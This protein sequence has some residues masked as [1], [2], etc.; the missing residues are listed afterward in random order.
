MAGGLVPAHPGALV[1]SRVVRSGV[2][3]PA[4]AHG[5]WSSPFQIS[6]ST[7]G[8]LLGAHNYAC[9]HVLSGSRLSLLATGHSSLC[10]L[11]AM[12]LLKEHSGTCCTRHLQLPYQGTV[13]YGERPWCAPATS[14]SLPKPEGGWSCSGRSPVWQGPVCHRPLTFQNKSSLE[15][16]I[17][18]HP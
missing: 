2:S 3:V 13:P 14:L 11:K 12:I 6:Q 8:G 10:L 16:K 9:G 15:I 5:N 1:T 7:A 18:S 17:K 4:T